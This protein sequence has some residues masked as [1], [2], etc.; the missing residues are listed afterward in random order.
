MS[1]QPKHNIE[2]KAGMIPFE[3]LTRRGQLRRLHRMVYELLANYDLEIAKVSFLTT[4]TNTYF[5]VTTTSGEKYALR[6]YSDEETTVRENVAEFFWLDAL[7]RDT[8]IRVTRPVARIDGEYLSIVNQS[9]LPPDRRCALFEWVPGT[10]L[11]QGITPGRYCQLGRIMA[12][13]H[14]H[15]ERLKLP[16]HI[17]PKRWDS[18]FYYWDEP[19]VIF[20]DNYKYI[21]SAPRRRI[22]KEAIARCVEY[23]DRLYGGDSKPSL[24]HGD[25]YHGN[26]HVHGNDLY[27]IDFEDVMIGFP[28]QDIAVTLYYGRNRADY[29]E[30][31]AAFQGGYETERAWPATTPGII[32]GLM[33]ARAIMF[34]N[35]VA[36]IGKNPEKFVDAK[37][38]ELAGYL[39]TGKMRVGEK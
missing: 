23:L 8:D 12:G 19:V 9:G 5:K 20:D 16:D 24:V 3:K 21:F 31:R 27:I 25:L 37:C 30:L 39:K 4:E 15:A 32:D 1:Q 34:V 11:E 36:R 35:Y 14:S 26:V 18:V 17:Q 33:A 22:L 6:I 10:R 29:P 13:L 2:K 28:V 7:M 38:R